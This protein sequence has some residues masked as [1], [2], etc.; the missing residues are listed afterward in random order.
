MAGLIV[1]REASRLREAPHVSAARLYLV[2]RPRR[3]VELSVLLVL[4][5]CLVLLVG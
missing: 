4:L 3:R 5:L 2:P 1:R